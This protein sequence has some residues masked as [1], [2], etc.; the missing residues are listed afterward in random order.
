MEGFLEGKAVKTKK[1]LQKRQG[2]GRVPG[3]ELLPSLGLLASLV[4]V[5][6]SGRQTR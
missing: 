5:W 4:A 6:P 1:H 3:L 2:W